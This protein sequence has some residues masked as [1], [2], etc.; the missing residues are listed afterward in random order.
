M[1][2]LKKDLGVFLYPNKDMEDIEI[3]KKNAKKIFCEYCDFTCSKNSDIERHKLRPKH[4]KN[5]KR[6]K[7]IQKNAKIENNTL[8]DEFCCSCGR[9][10]KYSSGLWR[11]K[12]LCKEKEKEEEDIM[13]TLTPQTKLTPELIIKLIDQTSTPMSVSLAPSQPEGSGTFSVATWNIRSGRGAGLAAAAKGL[14]QM[15]VGC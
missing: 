1:F 15:G 8:D 6:Y 13:K 7:M 10:Y 12:K 2:F 9:T 5:E 3:S 11:H 4:I 14:R